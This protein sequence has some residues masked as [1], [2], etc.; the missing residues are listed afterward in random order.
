MLYLACRQVAAHQRLCSIL[1]RDRLLVNL[2]RLE[3]FSDAYTE[4]QFS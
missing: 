2:H 1:G 4:L 3:I